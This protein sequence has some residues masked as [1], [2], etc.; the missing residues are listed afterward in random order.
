M[1]E[2]GFMGPPGAKKPYG[3]QVRS[4]SLAWQMFLKVN[5]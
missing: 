3:M 5:K 1:V 4:T 2:P